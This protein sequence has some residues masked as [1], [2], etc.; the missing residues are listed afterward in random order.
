[1]S[2]STA[3]TESG[4][5][6]RVD[7]A[8]GRR[9]AREPRGVERRTPEPGTIVAV[10]QL[11]AEHCAPGSFDSEIDTICRLLRRECCWCDGSLSRLR[12]VSAAARSMR[13]P[14]AV[15]SET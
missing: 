3:D 11:I 10:A 7:F 9:P 13:Q 15:R 12:A 6:V 2:M 1:M 4:R 5:V 8:A 14:R